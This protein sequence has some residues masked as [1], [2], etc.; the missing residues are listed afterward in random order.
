MHYTDDRGVP[1]V[2]DDFTLPYELKSTYKEVLTNRQKLCANNK[3][4]AEFMHFLGAHSSEKYRHLLTSSPD[5][6]RDSDGLSD[7]STSSSVADAR[8]DKIISR[9]CKAGLAWMAGKGG[10]IHFVLDRINISKV[11]HKAYPY[12]HSFT[13]I[14]LRWIYRNRFRAGVQGCVQFWNSGEPVIPPWET[15][16]GKTAWENYSPNL[17]PEK[18]GLVALRIGF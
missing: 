3:L 4:I 8:E 18:P 7:S 13:A 15:V 9:K 16:E 1:L 11:I 17:V 12:G 14:E 6:S 5:D 2:I 10:H